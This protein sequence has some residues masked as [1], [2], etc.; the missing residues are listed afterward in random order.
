MTALDI[1]EIALI[2]V[3]MFKLY[4][5][6]Y[7]RLFIKEPDDNRKMFYRS[8]VI[9]SSVIVIALGWFILISSDASSAFVYFQF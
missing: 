5:F 4:D 2:L 1:L 6:A 3:I 7:D 8:V 9:V